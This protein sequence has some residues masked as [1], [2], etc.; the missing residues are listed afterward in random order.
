MDLL[1][2]MKLWYGVL[3]SHNHS[4]TVVEA[5]GEFNPFCPLALRRGEELGD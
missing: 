4:G 1:L 2:D 3:P 5:G